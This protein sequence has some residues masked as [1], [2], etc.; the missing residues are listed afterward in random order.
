MWVRLLWVLGIVWLLAGLTPKLTLPVLS[1]EDGRDLTLLGVITGVGWALR[2]WHLPV[3]PDFFH[4]DIASQG[5]QALDILRGAA[6]GWFT[7]GWSNIPMF[8]YVMMAATMRL[9]GS[10]LLGLSLTAVW[11]GVLTLP[12]LYLLGREIGGRRVGLLAAAFLALNYTHI[13]FSR[14]VTTASPLLFMVATFYVLFRSRRRHSLGGFA[15][16]G[17][18]LG[19]GLLVYFP[20]R[21]SVVIVVLLF[22]W[23]LLWQRRQLRTEWQ[24]WLSFAVG[25]LL[26]FGPMM[27][28]VLQNFSA[29][30]G[31]GNVVT[32]ANPQVVAHLQDKYGVSSMSALWLEQ[33]KRTF[34][35]FFSVGDASTHFGFPGPMVSAGVAVLM[36]VGVLLCLRSL[37]DERH[38]VLLVWLLAT[39]VLGG[40]I[41]NDPPFWPHL[42][43]ALPAVMVLAAIGTVWL[44]DE[45]ARR[46]GAPW[47]PRFD[48]AAAVVIAL[49]LVLT[50]VHNWQAYRQVVGHNADTRVQMARYVADL[51]ADRHVWLIAEP[52]HAQEREFQFMD[53]HLMLTDV[54]AK[55]LTT[56]AVQ[57]P[58]VPTVFLLTPNHQDIIPWL[59]SHFRDGTL[60]EHHDARGQVAFSS[61]TL[62]PPSYVPPAELADPITSRQRRMRFGWIM[63]IV[64]L[65][66][67][68]G[69]GVWVWRRPVPASALAPIPTGSPPPAA[70][71]PQPSAEPAAAIPHRGL[72]FVTMA[73]AVLLAYGGQ[74]FYDANTSGTLMQAL[75][76]LLPATIS[77]NGLWAGSLLYALAM[78]LFALSAPALPK[79]RPLQTWIRRRRPYPGQRP[80][81]ARIVRADQPR[82]AT[83]Q[84]ASRGERLP[85]WRHHWR[86]L[87]VALLPYGASMFLFVWKGENG[88]VR[89]LWLAGLLLFVGAQVLWPWWRRQAG[90]Q[91]EASPAWRWYHVAFLLLVLI[92]GFWLRFYHLALI[93][94]DFHGDMASHGLQAR[95]ILAGGSSG[96]FHEGWAN[97]PM[98]AF[99]PATLTLKFF[100]NDIFGLR[101]ASVIGGM[102]VLLGLYL[103][104][105]RLFDRHRL[106]LLATAILA[107][108][109]PHIHFSRIAEYMD[110][111][112]FLVVALFFVVDGL[113]ARRPAALAAAGV[114]LGL[115]LQMYYSSRVIVFILAISL[116]YMWLFRRQWLTQNRKALFLLA[117]GGLVAL[118][119]SLIYFAT[120]SEALL[121]RSRSVFLFYEPVMTHLQ[122]KYGLSSQWAVL[123]EQIK[124]SLLM[125]HHSIDSS[126]QFGYPHPMFSSLLAPWVALGV[127][128]SLRHWRKPGPGLVLIWMTTIL[129]LGSIL[130]NNAPFWPRLVG[131]LPVAALLAGLAIDRGLILLQGLVAPNARQAPWL[132]AVIALGGIG[133]AGWGNWQLY[134]NTVSFNARGQARVG[135]YIAT[136][137][138][139]MAVCN[140]SDP[141][142]LAVRETYF[143]AWPRPLLD[144]PAAAPEGLIARC[145][146]PP[147]VWILTPN[148]MDRLPALQAR[149]PDGLLEDHYYGNGVLAFSSYMVANT[150][151]H[152]AQPV[153]A[154]PSIVPTPSAIPPQN[155]SSSAY[156]PDGSEFVP[157]QVF[158][159]NTSSSPW[160]IDAGEID[161]RGGKVILWVGPISGFDAVYDDV[162]LT[163][164]AGRVFLFEAEDP[165]ITVGDTYAGREGVDDHWWLQNYDAFSHGQGLVAQKQEIVP[166]L[167]S[168]LS[169]PAGHYHATIGSF[170]GDPDNGVFALGIAWQ[171]P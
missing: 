122:G 35:T 75:T 59:Q 57:A 78:L 84:A 146:G 17:V 72:A 7:I 45:A 148:H 139:D 143:L 63:G 101:M 105:W 169:L 152:E 14:I 144:L 130:T 53:Q 163:D 149:W 83:W 65:G 32:L 128:F 27:G 73:L 76:R 19:M 40:V 21:V 1:A 86:W 23:L 104:T 138:A 33:I 58:S 102:I 89:A 4:G 134:D 5:L 126:T 82:R 9:W 117:A 108:N 15:L 157:Q 30:V 151:I 116:L 44:W 166:A 145:P 133:V 87:A 46:L 154:A 18:L 64:L 119:P 48:L 165:G 113:K 155:P 11:Q 142:Q 141:F 10:D 140:F 120:H 50:G 121:E 55:A 67:M 13:H 111:W 36:V 22:L 3:L 123:G 80:P 109:I 114:L 39:L 62:T 167:Q 168:T 93:P 115:G 91:S 54:S 161:V 137:P 132:L 74:Q 156:L 96:W 47:R 79:P 71:A 129:V 100:G 26:G 164:A 41:T 85:I 81:D 29:F 99:M 61:Y 6:P 38:W 31:R 66:I 95:D 90:P 171:S 34:L 160:Q 103:L 97:I 25:S 112:S 42:V 92:G 8:D 77:T 88:L 153:G 110:P 37:R 56:G 170:S 52:Y 118:G 60:V 106:A 125:F 131:I 2:F 162:R 70:P 24:H 158:M 127:G 51:P 135:R 12:L 98:L 136:L 28:V 68:T 124:R 49:A 69:V 94:H 147:L 107:V 20:V 43:V 16:A 159:G 150:P